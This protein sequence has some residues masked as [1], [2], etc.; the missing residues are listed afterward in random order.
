MSRLLFIMILAAI[1]LTVRLSAQIEQ[2]AHSFASAELMTHGSLGVCVVDV[3]SN[4]QV[5]GLNEQVLLTPASTL[6]T[7]TTATALGVLGPD[8]QF[9]TWLEYD[10]SILPDGTL[11]G[12]LYVRGSGDPTLGSTEIEGALSLQALMDQWA[13]AVRAA[14]IRRIRGAV[15]GDAT[16]MSGEELGRDWE[17]Q[18]IGNYYGSG[19]WALNINENL[20]VITFRQQS[21]VGETPDIAGVEPAV[22]ELNLV[23]QLVSGAPGSGDQAY[24]FGGPYSMTRHIRGSIP[25]GTG[26]FS[27]KGSLPDPP[28]FVARRLTATLEAAGVAVG[29]APAGLYELNGVSNP[30]GTRE[31]QVLAVQYSPFLKEIVRRANQESVNLYCEA[32]LRAIGKQLYSSGTA[33]AGILGIRRFWADR[34]LSLDEAIIRDG[35]GLSRSNGIS[36]RHIVRMLAKIGRDERLYQPFIESLPV[37]GQN[38]TLKRVLAGTPAVGKVMAKSGS[39]SRVRAYAGYVTAKSGK[40]YAFA[41]MADRYVGSAAEVQAYLEQLMLAIY[42]H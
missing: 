27:I 6:K 17:W 3:E 16:E 11:D 7:L 28:L 14:G 34:G 18:D 9:T 21:S 8:Y 2:V 26:E 32:L 35:S 38:G 42:H 13:E 10:G 29:A 4:Q 1:G 41:I 31:R 15:I 40:Q 19:A 24:I 39:M 23:N 36:A 12:N 22:P 33:T 25:A 37:A 20:Y 30:K 5:V